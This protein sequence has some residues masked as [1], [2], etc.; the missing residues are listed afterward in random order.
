MS[1]YSAGAFPN[2]TETLYQLPENPTYYLSNHSQFTSDLNGGLSTSNL[3]GS[4]SQN[5]QR[6]SFTHRIRG[7]PCRTRPLTMVCATQRPLDCSMGWVGARYSI[8]VYHPRG[9]WHSTHTHGV[10]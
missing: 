2:K 7:T 10:P 9:T 6:L 5:V 3:G 1:R 4:F 8:R